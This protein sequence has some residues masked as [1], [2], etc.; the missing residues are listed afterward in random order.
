MRRSSCAPATSGGPGTLRK[1]LSR[2]VVSCAAAPSLLTPCSPALAP[3]C[4][5]ASDAHR[6]SCVRAAGKETDGAAGARAA[7]EHPA[8]DDAPAHQERR[9]HSRTQPEVIQPPRSGPKKASGSFNGRVPEAGAV[10]R[11]CLGG[12]TIWASAHSTRPFTQA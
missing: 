6:R 9:A 3:L 10:C 1:L 5:H 11:C 7:R 12:H 2:C 8:E 4:L